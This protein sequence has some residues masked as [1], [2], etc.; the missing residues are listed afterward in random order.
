MEKG[1][2]GFQGQ[3]GLHDILSPPQK[4][5]FYNTVIDW[6][7]SSSKFVVWCPSSDVTVFRNRGFKEVIKAKW[8][9]IS[10]TLI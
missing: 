5:T 7:V 10:G 1:G 4:D 8:D 2:S 6:I 3:P 9:H